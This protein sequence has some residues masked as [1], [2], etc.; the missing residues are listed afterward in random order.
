MNEKGYI[1]YN[2]DWTE[3]EPV[4]PAEEFVALNTWREVLYNLQMIGVNKQGFGYG[5]ISIRKDRTKHF[6]ITGSETGAIRSLGEEHYCLVTGYNILSNSLSCRGPVK[7]SSESM[8]HAVVYHTLPEIN[9]VIHIHHH[10]FW[11]ALLDKVP[12]TPKHIE[13]GTPEMAESIRELLRIPGVK[14]KRVIVMAGHRDGI[15]FFGKHLDEAGAFILSYFNET[16]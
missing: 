16:V 9:A 4:I 1:K 13:Y 3:S 8:S 5:N 7:A 2:L 10:D 15:L 11:S 6:F 12:V 14:E